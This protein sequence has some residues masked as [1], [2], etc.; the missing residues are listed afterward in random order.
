M[1]PSAATL[2][3]LACLALSAV[4]L[5]IRGRF[6]AVAGQLLACLAA[7][8]ALGAGVG[9]LLEAI[10]ARELGT[11]RVPA[12]ATI[13]IL[14]GLSFLLSLR[15]RELPPASWYLRT[16]GGEDAARRVLPP[17]LIGPPAI[18]V[19]FEAGL[20]WGWWSELTALTLFTVS[21]VALIGMLIVGGVDAVRSFDDRRAAAEKARA[22]ERRRVEA[23]TQRSPVGIYETDAEGHMLYLNERLGEMAGIA[24]GASD[25]VAIA[26]AVHPDDLEVV[27]EAWFQAVTTGS[28][29]EL[30]YRYLRP[31]GSVCW[32]IAHASPI[33]DG[34]GGVAGFLGTVQDVTELR[35]RESALR[36]AE[37][38]FRH[39]FEH[40]L[41][42]VALVSPEGEWLRVN[43]R[44][45][46]CS[47]TSEQELLAMTFQELTHP[48]GPDT[49]PGPVDAVAC[50]RDR[51][52]RD[53][54]ALHPRR[55]RDDLGPALGL[56][57]PRRGRRAALLRRAGPR[58]HRAP[59]RG[60]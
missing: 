56:A 39:A 25:D 54:E 24:P 4:L 7:A 36:E 38:R 30:D 6:P 1:E 35:Q 26:G 8:I 23:L 31:D 5:P 44:L 48:V 22:A 46:R 42:G 13:V 11:H 33:S 59:P 58:R 2:T 3:A 21:M 37:E 29:F 15:R 55:R 57:R 47:A 27:A 53:A 16:G 18:A 34:E 51:R 17:G 40:A 50:R 14:L 19:L 10:G 32:A 20:A 45:C 28:E 52:V 41:I 49:R 43:R 12:L 9:R 60:A